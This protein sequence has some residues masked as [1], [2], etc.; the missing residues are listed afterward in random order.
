[1]RILLYIF[2][3][4]AVILVSYGFYIGEEDLADHNYA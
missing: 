4:A 3:I 2:F 1:M